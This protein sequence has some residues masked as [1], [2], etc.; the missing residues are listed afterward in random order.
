[1]RHLLPIAVA[2]LQHLLWLSQLLHQLRIAAVHL[3][4]HLPLAAS[5]HLNQLQ[6]HAANLLRS[7]LLAASLLQNLLANQLLAV[8]SVS[9]SKLFELG[10]LVC[11]LVALAAAT[12]DKRSAFIAPFS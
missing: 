6:H 5:L 4:Q 8:A 7:Q 11:V 12:S 1:L 9:V 10:Y 3:S 2:V